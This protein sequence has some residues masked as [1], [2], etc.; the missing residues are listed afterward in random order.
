[1]FYYLFNTIF[2]CKIWGNKKTQ[3]KPSGDNLWFAVS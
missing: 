3:E 1:M 2:V